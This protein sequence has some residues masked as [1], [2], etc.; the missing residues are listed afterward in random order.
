MLVPLSLVT[1]VTLQ[2]A[3]QVTTHK[4]RCSGDEQLS[5][6]GGNLPDKGSTRGTLGALHS[7]CLLSQTQ[8]ATRGPPALSKSYLSCAH[9][10]SGMVPDTGTVRALCPGC[11]AVASQFLSRWSRPQV[12]PQCVAVNPEGI[13]CPSLALSHPLYRVCPVIPSHLWSA[14][15]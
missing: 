9:C 12:W 1:H 14:R 15:V 2:D 6:C 11:W 13:L 7:F 5:T 10:I 8:A 4:L 3:H